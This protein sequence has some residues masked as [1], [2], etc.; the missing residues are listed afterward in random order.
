[1]SGSG[2][3]S[4]T[5]VVR[6]L[7]AGVPSLPVART[8]SGTLALVEAALEAALPDAALVASLHLTERVSEALSAATEGS[9]RR[10]ADPRDHGWGDRLRE[11]W[12]LRPAERPLLAEELEPFLVTALTAPADVVAFLARLGASDGERRSAALLADAVAVQ[13]DAFAGTVGLVAVA[14]RPDRDARPA[15]PMDCRTPLRLWARLGCYHALRGLASLGDER[16][17]ALRCLADG[18]G[19]VEAIRDAMA[20]PVLDT[21]I[22]SADPALRRVL[23]RCPP[24][25]LVAS[26]AVGDD[27]LDRLATALATGRSALAAVP[28]RPPHALGLEPWEAPAV[29][30]LTV[31]PGEPFPWE[32]D[33]G[34]ALFDDGLTAS[35]TRPALHDDTEE[36]R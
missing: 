2:I 8:A 34:A 21:S 18:L 14:G 30:G 24:H 23:T 12:L 9:G 11:R 28:A 3:L 31:D 15:R 16:D 10:G 33:L 22:R 17:T 19:T 1:M 29:D 13:A 20:G 6:G 35:A 27:D 25:L 32:P 7:A 4:P 5:L 26:R 36:L